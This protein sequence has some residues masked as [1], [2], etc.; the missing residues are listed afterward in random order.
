MSNINLLPWR[1]ELRQVKNKR[2]LAI[3]TVAMLFSGFMVLCFDVFLA[4]R[5]TILE[6][7]ANYL[8]KS[9]SLVDSRV[10]EIQNLKKDKQD[11]LDRMKVIRSL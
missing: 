8:E 6:V 10:K 4:H 1:E 11:L 9:L 2:F 7:N 3:V 5:M